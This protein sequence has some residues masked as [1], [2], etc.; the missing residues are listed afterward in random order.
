LIR[1]IHRRRRRGKV[2]LPDCQWCSGSGTRGGQLRYLRWLVPRR[3]RGGW[4]GKAP[5]RGL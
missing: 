4:H 5:L 3:R 1:S 2:A